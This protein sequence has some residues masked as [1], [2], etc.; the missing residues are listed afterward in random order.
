MARGAKR[1]MLDPDNSEQI[2][3]DI[4]M[5][6]RSKVQELSSQLEEL[7]DGSRAEFESRMQSEFLNRAEGTFLWVGFAM[8]ELLKKRTLSQ[9][10][11]TIR[12]LPKGLSALYDRMLLQVDSRYRSTASKILR[13]VAFAARPLSIREIGEIIGS[14]PSGPVSAEQSTLDLLIICGPFITRTDH[15]VSLVHESVRE[16]I[17]LEKTSRAAALGDFHLQPYAVHLEMAAFCLA[18]I[19]QDYG[20]RNSIKQDVIDEGIVDVSFIRH[21]TASAGCRSFSKYAAL[22]WPEHARLSG[23]NF[24]QLVAAAP[25]FF[26][27]R[28]LPREDWW[29]YFSTASSLSPPGYHWS[30]IH[31]IPSLHMACFFGIA[32]WV[33]ELL[34]PKLGSFLR[35][36]QNRSHGRY[37]LTPL[38]YA[39]IGGHAAIVD[40]LLRN[41]AKAGSRDRTKWTALHHAVRH[42]QVEVTQI[43][44]EQ[45]ADAN[46]QEEGGDSVL[47][48]AARV[49]NVMTMKQ[50]LEHTRNPEPRSDSPEPNYGRTPLHVA[51]GHGHVDVMEYLLGKGANIESRDARQQTA[52]HMAAGNGN[53]KA[54]RLLLQK[55]ATV[56][57]RSDLGL[58]PLHNAAMSL[59]SSEGILESLLA[60]WADVNPRSYTGET[61]LHF[62]ASNRCT[63]RVAMYILLQ[64]GADFCART[65]S[66]MTPLHAAAQTLHW[67][68]GILESLLRAGAKIDSLS[69]GGHSPLDLALEIEP[70]S[71]CMQPDLRNARILIAH[72]ASVSTRDKTAV[73]HKAASTGNEQLVTVLLDHRFRSMI[74]VP[75]A[76]GVTPLHRAIIGS[77]TMRD[78][79]DDESFASMELH[80]F[81]RQH[82]A[83][84]AR[85]LLENGADIEAA[86]Q[87]GDTA[88]HYATKCGRKGIV[89]M[90]L[91][92]GADA[93]IKA[94]NGKTALQVARETGK[95][96]V[97]QLLVEHE[98][99]ML[100]EHASPLPQAHVPPQSLTLH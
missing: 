25:A 83:S 93:T 16:Y 6:I 13:W 40:Q 97:A 68:E 27:K 31:G 43:L 45:G 90:L 87:C 91:E 54:S 29:N 62:A 76:A 23:D 44:L 33:T 49:G 14:K 9:M 38:M 73:L 75:D 4:R 2:N 32:L 88:L 53:V 55:G 35:L 47:H 84:I 21:L 1:V 5:F 67:S 60:A 79:E 65:P 37:G 28:S 41:H 39:T 100:T 69:N 74:N 24:Q 36:R 80:V 56:D 8:I 63:T 99:E 15:I 34:R 52:L 22:H 26:A 57:V 10:E 96:D 64:A 71:S 94:K 85:H 82:P 48:F 66:G 77:D 20:A 18:Y 61:P 72:G 98:L 92:F 86:D 17:S 11:D 42:E 19:E 78:I 3:S 59:K 70:W 89:R 12:E 46:A 81:E 58:T 7:P 30:D 50:L 95:I 51:A